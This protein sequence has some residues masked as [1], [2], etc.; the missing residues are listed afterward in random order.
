MSQTVVPAPVF[1]RSGPEAAP[2]PNRIQAAGQALRASFAGS[3]GR[4]RLIAL[5]AVL[6]VVISAL[7]GGW[8]LQM[9]SSA[10]DRAKASSEHL[11]R[12]QSVQTKLVEANAAATNSFLGDGLEPQ[13]QRLDY[14]TALRDAS[15]ELA[16]AS[17]YSQDDAE[18]LGR[19]NALLTR[20]AGYIS[21]ARANNRQ[22]NTVGASYLQSASTL[23]RGETQEGRESEG[24]VP[25]LQAR[26]DA[27]AQVQDDAFAQSENARWL[28]LVAAVIGIGGLGYAQLLVTRHSHRYVNIP[29]AVSTVGLVAVLASAAVVMSSA[30][31]EA[32]DV[33]FGPL[34][35]ATEL[36]DSRVAAFDAKAQESL[37][38]ID[39]GSAT[40][41]DE[42]WQ[43]AYTEAVGSLDG[44]DYPD[45]KSALEQY[46]TAHEEVND[47]DLR[48]QWDDAVDQAISSGE[49]S[50]NA[51]FQSYDDQTRL[52]LDKQRTVAL[53][54]LGAAN[55]SLLLI[56][57]LL[58]VI[59]VLCAAGAWWG[60]SLRL[61][62]Y[63]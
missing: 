51:L 40:D 49:G 18:T 12:L 44:L 13:E 26:A 20:Y 47:L 37:T 7:L 15:S 42:D 3:P 10:L 53:D 46:G 2:P 5:G 35:R 22:G 63:R 19:A 32:S 45:A 28:L 14:I 33:R 27:S 34:E 48:G 6:S 55:D 59:G 9:R 29:A 52:S 23:L 54:R 1:I 58:L 8:A 50:G 21:S 30:Q 17:R 36:S 31:S 16:L 62:E 60:I 41:A 24:I 39:R 4:L 57:L 11:L 38:L 56:A 43:D 25:L 61:D